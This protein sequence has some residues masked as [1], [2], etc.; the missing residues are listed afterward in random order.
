M[1][2]LIALYG[3]PDD[4]QAFDRHYFEVHTPLA[5]KMPGLRRLEASPVTGSPGGEPRYHL[6]AEMYFDDQAALNA[7]MKSEEGKAAARDLMSFAG[8][9]V[10]L[11]V[12]EVRAS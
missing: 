12:A 5:R 2:K 9:I 1:V 8:K 11:M 6:V 7:A 10:H 3:K 4:P